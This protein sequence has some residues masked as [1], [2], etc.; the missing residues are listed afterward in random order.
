MTVKQLLDSLSFDEIAP[1][2]AMRSVGP[3]IILAFHKQ[4][5]DYLRHLVPTD[6]QLLEQEESHIYHCKDDKGVYLEACSLEGDLG[7]RQSLQGTCH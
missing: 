7:G 5:Y 2:I 1:Y 6:P 4:H 3:K